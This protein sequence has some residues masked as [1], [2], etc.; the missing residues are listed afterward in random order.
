[1]LKKT[2]KVTLVIIAV[3]LLLVLALFILFLLSRP[4]EPIDLSTNVGFIEKTYNDTSRNRTLNAFMWFPTEESSE[5]ELSHSNAMFFGFSARAG[6]APS[7]KNAPLIIMSHGSGGNISNQAW[8][9]VELAKRGAVVIAANHPGSTSRDSAPST[10]LE[11]WNRPQDISFMLDQVIKDSN[12][13][14]LIDQSRIAAIGHSLG[15]YTVLATGGG[16]LSKEAF[17]D[18]CDTYPDNPDCTFY[19]LGGID[20]SNI[21]QPK[22]EQLHKDERIRAL[23]VLDPAYARSF[24][25]ESVIGIPP[26]LLI[27]PSVEKNSIDD[28]QVDFLREQLSSSKAQG[29]KNLN[30]EGAHHFSFIQRCKPYANYIMGFLEKGAEVLCAAEK[31]TDRKTIHSN[32]V[33]EVVMFFKDNAILE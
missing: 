26:T 24:D 28:L 2:L 18:Y 30:F 10:N 29:I 27:T 19:R 21:N 33:D 25:D 12:I 6:A 4:N 16:V 8:L 22:F 9:A 32:V 5:P 20:L 15:G 3:L 11:V 1:M 14:G 17:I 7:V 23:V 13:S 31:G